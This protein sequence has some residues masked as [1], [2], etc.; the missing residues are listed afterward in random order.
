MPKNIL[1]H[2]ANEVAAH[3][4]A[5]G[6]EKIREIFEATETSYSFTESTLQRAVKVLAEAWAQ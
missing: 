1:D 2:A 4:Q 3:M 5:V 6:Y